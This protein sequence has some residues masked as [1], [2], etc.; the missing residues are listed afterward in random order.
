MYTNQIKLI[1]YLKNNFKYKY[2]YKTK[3][4]TYKNIWANVWRDKSTAH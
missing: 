1:F 3:I 4:Q 2:T